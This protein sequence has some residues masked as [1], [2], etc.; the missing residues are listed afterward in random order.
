[1]ALFPCRR[2]RLWSNESG[3]RLDPRKGKRKSLLAAGGKGVSV[4]DSITQNRAA[5]EDFFTDYFS[6][7]ADSDLCLWFKKGK[8]SRTRW[9]PTSQDGR[10]AA[11]SAALARAD[12]CDVYFG[13]CP[14]KDSAAIIEKRGER[15]RASKEDISAVPAL[16]ADIDLAGE[17][18]KSEKKYAP[19]AEAWGPTFEALP[20]SYVIHSGHGLHCYWILSEPFRIQNEKDRESIEETVK[21]FQTSLAAAAGYDIDQTGDLA[22][23]LRVP[24]TVN[25]KGEALPVEIVRKSGAR[26]ELADLVSFNAGGVDAREPEELPEELPPAR[27]RKKTLKQALSYC[28]RGRSAELFNQLYDGDISGY[29]SLSEALQAFL[30][31]VSP[32]CDNEEELT[33]ELVKSSALWDS[34]VE[35]HGEKDA[36]RK[37][38]L[39]YKKA[40]DSSIPRAGAAASESAGEIKRAGGYQWPDVKENWRHELVPV[41]CSFRN[42]QY[43]METKGITIKYDELKKKLVFGGRDRKDHFSSADL[44]TL[45]EE[46]ALSYIRLQCHKAGLNISQAEIREAVRSISDLARFNPVQDW[47][48]KARAEYNGEDMISALYARLHLSA[49]QNEALCKTLFR[50]WLISAARLAFNDDGTRGASGILI[51]CGDQGIGKTRFVQSLVPFPDWVKDGVAVD[52]AQKDDV[53]RVLKYWIVELGEIGQTLR[54][55]KRDRLKAFFTSPIDSIRRPYGRT[56]E[57][58]PRRTAF[59]G[60]VNLEMDNGFLTDPTGSRRFW[61]IRVDSIDDAPEGFDLMQLWGH[62]MAAAE[63][64]TEYLTRAE[65]AEVIQENIQYDKISAEEKKILDRLDWTAPAIA[66]RKVTASVLAEELNIL[67]SYVGRVGRALVHIS[68]SNPAVICPTNNHDRRYLLPPVLPK[69]FDE[70]PPFLP[71]EMAALKNEGGRR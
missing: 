52:P 36:L 57:E 51:L 70:E 59:I 27:K 56:T 71:E 62:V 22:R 67:S 7:C 53:L 48:R 19:T 23:V 6:G 69:E 34:N 37:V 26:Y 45:D 47:L 13:V 1:M 28:R 68:K 21:R 49:G 30:N 44:S 66:W 9:E 38:R 14:V 18:H 63:T 11:A 35:K 61:P 25:H 58:I 20:P 4:M 8:Q 40:V 41:S 17:G 32:R 24:C 55:E 3:G 31:I 39:A 12:K 54:R 33:L 43:L 10:R 5:V 29:P 46:T 15:A 64:E 65:L 16:W 60:T 2:L 50:K 42:V